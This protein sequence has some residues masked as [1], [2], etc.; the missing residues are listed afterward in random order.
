MSSP[1]E[2]TATNPEK[3]SDNE[4]EVAQTKSEAALGGHVNPDDFGFSEAEQKAIIR[5]IDIRLV[6]TVG[7]MYC[8]SLMDRTNLGAANIAGMA[9]ELRLQ[10][11]QYSII[12]LLFFVTYIA[13]QPPSTVIVRAI[14]PRI[15]LAAITFAWG[16]CMI[17]MGF[18][19]NWQVMAGLRVV[20]GVL[21]AGEFAPL[22]SCVYLLSTW[23]TRYDVGVRNS[24]FYMVGCVAAAF[25]GI[26]AYGI[27]HMRGLGGLGGWRWIFIIEGL[28]TV[29]IGI[30][31]YWLLVDFPDSKRATWNFLGQRERDWICARVQADRGDVKAPPFSLKAYLSV[32]KDWKVWAYALLFFNTTTTTYALAYFLPIILNQNL[33]FDV[34]TSQCLVAPP[35]V[36][37]GI[38]MYGT[39]WIGDKYRIRGP[40]VAFNMLLVLIG[41][42]IMGFHANNAV[43]YF[44]VFL[45]TAG[46]N[47]NVPA[48]M[49]YQANNIRGQWKRAFC[50]ATFVSFGGIGGIAGS[51]VFREEDRPQYKAG[52]YACITTSLANLII[53]TLLSI[54]FYSENRKADRGEKE[55]EADEEDFQPGFRYTY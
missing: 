33:G 9:V 52:L 55:L 5:R 43:R 23:Y 50:S 44:G 6:L 31:G 2:K 53:V 11:Y 47:S 32:G 14:G 8:V 3:S 48:M 1:I 41:L 35:Y 7:A 17:G 46:A 54:T 28:I 10:G 26:L 15:H 38:V 12:S 51:L 36:L 25:A 39:S 19:G 16:C 30:A 45:V 24:V 18:S 21:E 4:V 22:P 42:P 40:I 37:A 29:V 27:M 34:G 20:L 49:S 13:F